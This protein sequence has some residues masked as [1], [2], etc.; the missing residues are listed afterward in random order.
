MLKPIEKRGPDG[1]GQ[2]VHSTDSWQV[3]FGHR[4]LS[5]IDLKSGAQP[6]RSGG[7]AITYNGEVY[8]F[9]EIRDELKQQ[10][11][12]FKTESDTEV[13]LEKVLKQGPGQSIPS[14][15]G[16]FAFAVWD[17]SAETLVLARD[18]IG[19]KPL[20]YSVLQDGALVF[21]S[22]L[23]SIL[24]YPGIS[25]EISDSSLSE[26]F[27]CD[28]VQA[29]RTIF[30][31]VRKLE[32][33]HFLVWKNGRVLRHERY[34]SPPKA[35]SHQPGSLV[36]AK[37]QLTSHLVASVRRQLV[38]DVPVGVFLS[39]GVDSSVVAAVAQTVSPRRLQTFSVGFEEKDFDESRFAR[40]VARHIQSEHSEEI[41][42]EQRL[43]DQLNL[44]LDTLDEP[45]SD[46]SI[47]PT[48]ILSSLASRNVKVVLGGDG[49]DELWAG[50]PTYRALRYAGIY[51]RFPRWVRENAI[52]PVVRRLE[53]NP[54]YQSFEWKAKRFALRFDD[55]PVR[56][57]LR[58]MSN[59]DL[60][61]LK[62]LMGD[63]YEEPPVISQIKSQF[64]DR[65]GLNDF[66][67]LDLETYLPGDVL[68]KV[69]RASMGNSLEVRPPLLDNELVDFA[70]GLTSNWKLRGGVG[71]YLLKEVALD[72]LP[73]QIVQR[74]KKGFAIPLAR[75]L[76]GP[77]RKRLES[78]F[79]D[80]PLWTG[81]S[82]SKSTLL[83]WNAEHQE[84]RWDH[85]KPLW[86]IIVLDHWH[87]RNLK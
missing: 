52:S 56:R 85:S 11:S 35:E 7:S 14:F 87:R 72:F 68:T 24:Q 70:F 29:P 45:L 61:E 55:D 17:A 83:R 64:K 30:K 9:E 5:I 82:L 54:T 40:E 4:R 26:Y 74:P 51:S 6:M 46:S 25:R 19:I 21:A 86:S 76:K 41:L 69:D 32:P 44:A 79:S 28:T 33:A 8:N 3:A 27:F 49:G 16:M 37:E 38:S 23:S 18:R 67:A 39:G 31:A 75:W 71:K 15:N 13:V 57:H 65:S 42:S 20:Y 84:G 77:L 22:T 80:S 34:W 48:F 78:I 81:T 66:L 63:R 73:R 62:E 60:P 36:E 2:W 12:E 10:G 58:W 53:V 59:T 43:I 50:Y 1:Q 47:I